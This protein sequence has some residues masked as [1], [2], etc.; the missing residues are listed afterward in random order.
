MVKASTSG[1]THPLEFIFYCPL[2]Q[3]CSH[4][5]DSTP[6]YFFFFFPNLKHIS[7]PLAP[8]EIKAQQKFTYSKNTALM[9]SARKN[10]QINKNLPSLAFSSLPPSFIFS[11][12]CHNYSWLSFYIVQRGIVTFITITSSSSE[13]LVIEYRPY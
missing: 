4:C 1:Q 3:H 12:L 6:C 8:T 13:M 5:P 10:K 11:Y 2:L 9:S 7:L